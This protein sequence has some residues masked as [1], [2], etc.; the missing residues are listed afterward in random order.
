ML[1]VI[2]SE[3]RKCPGNGRC[4]LQTSFFE[5]NVNMKIDG[6]KIK[7]DRILKEFADKLPKFP[8]GR[9]D[10]TYSKK[11][12]VIICFVKFQDDILILKRSDKVGVYRERWN[13]V[14]GYLDEPKSIHEKALEEI[15][16]ELGVLREN[17]L[18][19]I[20]GTPYEY[21]DENIQKTWFIHPVLAELKLKPEIKL[22]WEHTDFKWIDPKEITKYDLVSNLGESLNRVL[23]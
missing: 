8:D 3:K 17:V 12:P 14:A 22:D 19:I 1:S 2:N 5:V 16:E 18:R 21:F 15:E 20:L 6:R 13:V 9:I 4:N 7:V 10:Y 11:A 23:A